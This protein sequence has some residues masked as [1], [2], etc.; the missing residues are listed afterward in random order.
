MSLTTSA[1]VVALG[2]HV[3]ADDVARRRA[4]ASA[5]IAAPMPRE[6]PVTTATRPASGCSQSFGSVFSPAPIR[7]TWP[8]TYAER[9]Q[10]RKRSVDSALASAPGATYTSCAVAPWRSSLAAERD[11]A[12]ERALGH[13]LRAA[14]GE[15]GRRAEHDEAAARRRACGSR[16]GRTRRAR[17]GPPSPSMPVASK[18]SAPSSDG[19]LVVGLPHVARSRR[20]A[21]ASARGQRCSPI[22]PSPPEQGGSGEG[23]LAGLVTAQ[24]ARLGQAEPLGDEAPGG[25]SR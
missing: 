8:E 3:D 1:S 17:A 13:R 7:T 10:S 24:R 4:P 19:V 21:A 5:A 18:T 20:R 9:A 15:L 22:R 23:G 16:R 11:E 14:G 25:R 12:L 6:A 2:G